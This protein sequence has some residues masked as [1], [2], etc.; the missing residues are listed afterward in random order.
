ME[1]GSEGG[2]GIL[3]VAI[4]I[5]LPGCGAGEGTSSK[6]FTVKDYD[7]PWKYRNSPSTSSLPSPPLSSSSLS[8]SI[9]LFTVN[10]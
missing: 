8:I 6:E 4:T 2:E 10:S 3:V 1:V 5:L 7:L 9:A